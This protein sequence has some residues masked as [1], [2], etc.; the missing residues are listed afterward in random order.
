MFIIISYDDVGVRF[1]YEMVVVFTS[2]VMRVYDLAIPLLLLAPPT[3][4]KS[5]PV[6]DGNDNH[7]KQPNDSSKP[8]IIHLLM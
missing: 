8:T 6:M 3:T 2:A 5:Q 7:A 1:F 4:K